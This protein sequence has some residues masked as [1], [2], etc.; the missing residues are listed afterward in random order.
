[1]ITKNNVDWFMRKPF[2]LNGFFYCVRI[3][4]LEYASDLG[5]EVCRFDSYY[6]YFWRDTMEDMSHQISVTSFALLSYFV[7]KLVKGSE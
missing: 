5:S 7:E 1:M 4:E 3:A 6:G 2:C